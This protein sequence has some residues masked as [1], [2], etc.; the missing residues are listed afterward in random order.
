MLKTVLGIDGISGDLLLKVESPLAIKYFVNLEGMVK[1]SGSNYKN[2]NIEKTAEGATITFTPKSGPIK[3][4]PEDRPS[5]NASSAIDRE[6]FNLLSAMNDVVKRF[7]YAANV[8]MWKTT[9]II[10]I[11]NFESG[12]AGEKAYSLEELKSDLVE[13]M[14]NK[15]DLFII[16]NYSNYI[17]NNINGGT[18]DPI[19]SHY[20][21]SYNTMK[22][23][24][25][26]FVLAVMSGDLDS[27]RKKYIPLLEKK[28]LVK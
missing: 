11:L 25:V 26:D 14:K 13:A 16:D 21:I 22:N 8:H 7:Y 1:N 19:Y 12:V 3:V 15:R 28:D 5:I 18:V 9:E 27:V 24:Y 23:E 4:N 6:D 20:L 10:P 2:L 17:S